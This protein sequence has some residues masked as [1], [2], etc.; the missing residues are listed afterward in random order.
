MD[1]N[2]KH[3]KSQSKKIKKTIP[4]SKPTTTIKKKIAKPEPQKKTLKKIIENDSQGHLGLFS[5][6]EKLVV[7][8]DVHADYEA[9]TQT[10]EKAG[11]IN[12]NLD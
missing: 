11:L 12:S 2:A 8:G 1:K 3:K 9:L 7:I 5:M 10:M 4:K 6:P